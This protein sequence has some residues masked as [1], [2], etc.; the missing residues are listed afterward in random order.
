MKTKYEKPMAMS[1]RGSTAEG[2]NGT[3]SCV[4]GSSATGAW[5]SPT[6][7][8]TGGSASGANCTTG[9]VAAGGSCTP[10]TT[11]FGCFTGLH[12]HIVACTGG[13]GF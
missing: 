10:G 6:D 9:S 4:D 8:N 3:N 13:S 12:P 5:V 7:C 11:V 2:G 1:V